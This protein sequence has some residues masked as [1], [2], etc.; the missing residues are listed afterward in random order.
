MTHP[1]DVLDLAKAGSLP[2]A[3]GT[4]FRNPLRANAVGGEA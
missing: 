3:T 2:D 4:H 1:H